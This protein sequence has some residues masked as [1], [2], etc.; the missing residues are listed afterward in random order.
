M[1]TELGVTEVRLKSFVQQFQE[2]YAIFA[3][4]VYKNRNQHRRSPYFQ[5]LLKVRRDL[6]LLNSVNLEELVD[7]C[8]VVI[9][10]NKPKAKVHLLES[11]KRRKCDYGTPNFMERLLGAARLLSMIVEPILKAACKIS[12]LLA[13][14]FFKEFSLVVLASLGRLRVLTQQM[15]LDV[16]S[17]FNRVSSLSQKR[18]SVKIKKKGI[19]AFRECYPANKEIVILECEWMTDKFVLHERTRNSDTKGQDKGDGDEFIK[20]PA[21]QYSVMDSVLGVD[22]SEFEKTNK[23]E[24]TAGKATAQTKED[25]KDVHA[26]SVARSTNEE[27]P[28]KRELHPTSSPSSSSKTVAFVSV[29]RPAP[30]T[31]AFIS[32]KR[33]A[34]LQPQT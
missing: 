12:G 10:G 15:L 32:V 18:Q 31:P 21:L 17:T 11:L 34:T 3:R 16:V 20:P 22:D 28:S 13:R 19:E 7:S 26:G 2:E 6:K 30:S 23:E 9:T 29:K 4:I 24:E 33:P 1:G 25:E 14:T 8:S 5:Y 27:G